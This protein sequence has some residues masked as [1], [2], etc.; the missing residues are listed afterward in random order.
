MIEGNE[1]SLLALEKLSDLRNL[2]LLLRVYLGDT[3]MVT[4]IG[5]IWW[6]TSA[7]RIYAYREVKGR[8]G[9]WIWWY[10]GLANRANFMHEHSFNSLIARRL[11][12][13]EVIAYGLSDI[14]AMTEAGSIEVPADL[15]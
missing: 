11:T 6:F 5:S 12:V 7:K 14:C 15:L 3:P 4:E 8:T 2:R 1:K 9:K 10:D 13:G